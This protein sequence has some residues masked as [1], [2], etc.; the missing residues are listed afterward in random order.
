M[1]KIKSKI[2]THF[3]ILER[4]ERDTKILARNNDSEIQKH[5]SYVEKQLDT[6]R[7]M[8]YEVLEMIDSNVESEIVDEWVNITNEKME[9]YQQ[10][11][12]RLK[13]CLDDL[14]EKKEAEIRRKEDEIPEQRFKRRM[15]EESR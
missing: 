13:G 5:V 3:K 4:K 11:V 14:R 9:R 10:S 6:V 12:D 7:A 1:E 2:T 15:E 8:K